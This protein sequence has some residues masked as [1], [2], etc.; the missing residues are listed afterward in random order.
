MFFSKI[1]SVNSWR[2]GAK[3]TN[4]LPMFFCFFAQPFE[5]R[6]CFCKKICFF[7]LQKVVIAEKLFLLSFSKISSVNSWRICGTRGQFLKR[8]LA[9]KGRIL[10]IFEVFWG[11]GHN[12]ISF[13]KNELEY[14][15]TPD[16]TQKVFF[17]WVQK[18]FVTPQS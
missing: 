8:W 14:P 7:F 18:I 12:F 15:G 9:G 17:A 2:I 1:I 13:T 16:G 10:P 6:S 3:G 5:K 4:I 11:L